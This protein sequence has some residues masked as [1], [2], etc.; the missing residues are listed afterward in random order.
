MISGQ[1]IPRPAVQMVH[2]QLRQTKHSSKMIPQRLFSIIRDQFCLVWSSL[3]WLPGWRLNKALKG[4]SN[5]K[6]L[7]SVCRIAGYVYQ[8]EMKGG[9]QKVSSLAVLPNSKKR[10]FE[11]YSPFCV[12]F[13]SSPSACVG[14]LQELQFQSYSPKTCLY[15]V[16]FL[17]TL[18]CSY[19]CKHVGLIVQPV[20]GRWPTG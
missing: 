17:K 6:E 20:I 19:R 10:W 9:I 7:L 2:V 12:G 13:T 1:K 5:R 4:Y 14:F 3:H 16:F 11:S 18:N 8:S 15:V